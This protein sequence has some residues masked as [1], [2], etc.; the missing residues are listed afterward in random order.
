MTSVLQVIPGQRRR[1]QDG[2]PGW[3][4]HIGREFRPFTECTAWRPV[5][6]MPI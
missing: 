2:C 3:Q 6:M 1:Q 4:H 5:A